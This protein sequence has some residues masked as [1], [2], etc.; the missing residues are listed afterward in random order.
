MENLVSIVIP[1]Y[2]V[3]DYLNF[4]L[5]SIVAQS[6]KNLEVLLVNDGSTDS[7]KDVCDLWAKKDLR[8]R[9]FHKS[10]GGVSSA[11]NLGI[12]KAKGQYIMFVDGDDWLDANAVE[13]LV[14]HLEATQA[15]SCFCNCYYKNEHQILIATKITTDT[16]ISSLDVA[17]S[18]LQYGFIASPWLNLTRFPLIEGK[19]RVLSESV[20]SFSNL[21]PLFTESIHTLEDWEYN[22][23]LILST[24]RIA[25]L[26]SPYYH[27]RTVEGSASK[28][29]L[30][31]RK[32]SCFLIY[33]KVKEFI[34]KNYPDLLE[35]T[36]YVPIFLIYHMLVIYSGN[37]AIE[38]TIE[39][40]KRIARKN[41]FY[42]LIS[43]NVSLRYKV[44]LIL[45]SIHPILFKVLY[46]LKNK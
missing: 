38:N 39:Q 9:V 1:A 41:L 7:T 13:L 29:P 44:Y 22:L 11:R 46:N 20:P 21:H 42:A 14:N 3:G 16:T 34:Q 10:N 32:M 2:N 27:Y 19:T 36:R 40:L 31:E 30:N 35:L 43:S 6:Y 37:G 5:E 24:E 33:E 26:S 23:R 25:I 28:S 18:H 8:I 4:C 12:K 15:D 45:A 17:K